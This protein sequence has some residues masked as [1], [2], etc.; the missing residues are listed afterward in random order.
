ME[1]ENQKSST[2]NDHLDINSVMLATSLH[3]DGYLMVG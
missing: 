2:W 1:P 3:P